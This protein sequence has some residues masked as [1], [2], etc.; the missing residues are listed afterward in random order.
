MFIMIQLRGEVLDGHAAW[1]GIRAKR[2]W[3][4]GKTR[5][6]E[7]TGKKCVEIDLREI[8]CCGVGWMLLVGDREEVGGCCGH[9]NDPSSSIH[10][11]EVL[12][13]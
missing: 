7:P 11:G 2:R 9:G 8:V 1:G 5:S 3:E 10:F 6:K 12:K 13:Q 4:G